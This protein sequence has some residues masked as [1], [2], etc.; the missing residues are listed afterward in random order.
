MLRNALLSLLILLMGKCYAQQNFFVLIQAENSQPFYVKLDDK[1]LSSNTKGRLILAQLKDGSHSINIGSPRQVF[2]EQQY[3]FKI[4]GK[5]LE[6]QLKDLGEK[7]WGLFNPLTLELFTADKKETP[8]TARNEGVKKDDAFSRLM[9]GVVSDTAVMYNTYAMEAVLK[10]S[11]VAKPTVPQVVSSVVAKTDSPT[12]VS[13]PPA[14]ASTD[15]PVRSTGPKGAVHSSATS[16]AGTVVKLSERKTPKGLRLAFADR[17]KGRKA[18]TIILIIPTDTARSA[19]VANLQEPK[20]DSTGTSSAQT[21]PAQTT[22]I[23]ATSSPKELYRTKSDSSTEFISSATEKKTDST[24]KPTETVVRSNPDTIHVYINAGKK[25]GTTDSNAASNKSDSAGEARSS[26]K[27]THVPSTGST[28]KSG[29]KPDSTSIPVASSRVPSAGT[30][31]KTRNKPDSARNITGHEL[32]RSKPDSSQKGAGK[33]LVVN[34]DCRN[35]AAD[36]DVDKLRVK[37]LE[38][39]KDEDRILTAKKVFKT[40]CFTTKQIRALSEVF[41]TDAGKYHFFEAAYPFVSDDRF[42]ELTDLLADPV[43]NGKFRALTGQQ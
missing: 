15:P 8:T 25:P 35:F 27:S 6:F 20:P 36:Y 13:S 32:Y 4:D 37:M 2:S 29:N 22:T 30:P 1:S 42:R 34:S 7:G 16:A 26:V 5:D 40:K 10:D 14:S 31:E 33:L 18:D 28:E 21:T 12:A 23:Q 11:P 24:A 17:P 43:Y 9:A 19:S 41:T 38:G 3:T 39:S